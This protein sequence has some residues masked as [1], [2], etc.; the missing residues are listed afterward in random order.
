MADIKPHITLLL[1][2]SNKI[3]KLLTNTKKCARAKITRGYL[4][5]RVEMLCEYWSS[6]K[7]QYDY[8]TTTYTES[9]FRTHNFEPQDNYDS[10]E[11]AYLDLKT[12]IK[13][14][15]YEHETNSTKIYDNN[16]TNSSH[17]RPKLAPI[18]LPVF[19]G[20]YNN[21][22]SFRDLYVSLIHNDNSLSK[23]EKFHYLKCSLTGDA[24][25]LIKNFTLTEA[26]YLDAWKKLEER[27]DNKRVIVN[28]ILNRL[29]S[30]KKLTIESAK[31]LK[32]LLD[33]TS[34]CLDSLKNLSILVSNWDAILVYII[35]GKLDTESHK[36]WEQ[37]LGNSTEIPT[38]VNLASF[39]ENRFRTLE[40][41]SSTQ[42]K[43]ISKNPY[44][45]QKV[46]SVKSYATEVNSTCTYCSQNHYICHCKNFATLYI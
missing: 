7:K 8:I 45:S 1:H 40:M 39:L 25:I 31:G 16:T 5:A 19:S 23:I 42:V 11:E 38:Y 13:D 41:I 28:N 44:A 46:T 29:L 12:W 2:N 24:A 37:S 21:W 17:S 9:E 15:L 33:T 6:Y 14:W 32:E 22:I 18:P 36:L 34:Q 10:S 35:V 26:N 4:E 43:D 30:Q 3:V 27:Y 20:D